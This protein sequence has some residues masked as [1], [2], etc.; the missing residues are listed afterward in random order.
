[1]YGLMTLSLGTIACKDLVG[2]ATLPAGT[3]DPSTYNSPSGAYGMYGGVKREV[4]IMLSGVI[5]E[6][7]ALTDELTF[8]GRG[9]GPADIGAT[10]DPMD[11]RILPETQTGEGFGDSYSTLHGVRAYAQEA[12][13]LLAQYSPESSSALRGEMYAVSGYAEIFLADLYCSGIPLSTLDFQKD[14]TYRG[15]STTTQV[16]THAVAL[17]DTALAISSDSSTVMNLARVGKARALLALGDYAGAL[18]T[19]MSVPDTFKYQVVLISSISAALENWT[20]SDREGINGLP[21]V[22]SHDPRI[23][24]TSVG[25]NPFG[26]ALFTADKYSG[27]DTTS[28]ILASGIEARLIQAEAELHEGDSRW[29][30]SLNALRTSC[31]DVNN[32]PSPAPAGIGG[33][34]GL[35]PLSDPGSDSAR[36]TLVFN[37]RAYWLFLTGHRQG[38]LRRLVRDY[39]RAQEAVYPSG[40]YF[41]GHGVYGSDITLPIPPQERANP[42]FHGCLNRRA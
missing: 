33:V 27:P 6:S 29:L 35:P 39:N 3:E 2:N 34:T 19:V 18:E 41:G 14:F 32:C 25:E 12:I 30:A 31:T 15:S 8:V 13:G 4:G 7:G 20:V 23:H 36:I 22:S 11:E 5:A 37:E 21:F 38:D 10:G 26:L 1:M 16:Y 40:A 9:N 17:F 28:A 24:V 42:M